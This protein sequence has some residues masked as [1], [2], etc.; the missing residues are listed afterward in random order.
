MAARYA[1]GALVRTHFGHS[2]STPQ[3]EPEKDAHD[4][5]FE[6]RGGRTTVGVKADQ[7]L[8]TRL[9]RNNGDKEATRDE[10]IALYHAGN[11]TNK[12]DLKRALQILLEDPKYEVPRKPRTGFAKFFLGQSRKTTRKRSKRSKKSKTLKHKTPKRKT[13]KHKTPKRKTIKRKSRKHA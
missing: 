3:T 12:P 7:I 2:S 1:R 11:S 6:K 9:E 8:S 13:L 5:F 4:I 10:L